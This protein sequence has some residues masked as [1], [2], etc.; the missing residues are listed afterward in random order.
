MKQSKYN[1]DAQRYLEKR[2]LE[3]E[4]LF[5][6][7]FPIV[8]P[9]SSCGANTSLLEMSLF[10]LGL[11]HGC[12]SSGL[13]CGVQKE[14]ELTF[15]RDKNTIMK[16]IPCSMEETLLFPTFRVRLLNNIC[17]LHI[18]NISFDKQCLLKVSCRGMNLN[19]QQHLCY[20]LWFSVSP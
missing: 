18:R 1:A 13:K 2:L 12:H 20:Y 14:S 10:S 5:G 11:G 6:F 15:L 3:T 7:F 9:I 4:N 16:S 17:H 19:L 8:L